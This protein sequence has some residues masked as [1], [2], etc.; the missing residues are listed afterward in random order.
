MRLRAIASPIVIVLTTLSCGASSEREH[1]GAISSAIIKGVDS[2][3]DQDAVVLIMHYDAVQLGGGT[4]GCTGIMLTPRL[5]LTARHCVSITDESAACDENGNPTF[6]AS[7][8]S[9][10]VASKLYAFSGTTRPDFISG[11]D[12]AARGQEIITTG[13]KTLC[14]NDIALLLLDKPMRNAKIA[15]VRLDG[16]PRKDELVTVVGWGVTEKSPNPDIRQQ[17]SGVKVVGV[18]P[19]ERLGPAESLLGESGCSG[20]SGGPAFSAETGAVLG[21][22]SRGG[23]GSGAKPGDFN[24][25]VEAENVFSSAAKHRDL[26]LSAYEKAGQAPW[27]EGE[28]DP[29]LPKPATAP[30][31]E[32]DAGCAIG[33]SREGREGAASSRR[34]GSRDSGRVAMTLL[35]LGLACAMRRRARCSRA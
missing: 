32:A 21:V 26:I 28:A 7:V 20:D 8:K 9:D 34:L 35:A 12:R 6:G 19:A 30:P 27:N 10:H 18:G 22:L 29:T 24:A 31:E 11:L 25:C 13:A 4:A 33:A 17:R 23:N 5:V 15:P 1:T 14:N 3:A 2:P 16:G